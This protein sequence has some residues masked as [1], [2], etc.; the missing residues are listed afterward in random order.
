MA[1][2]IEAGLT[3]A[4]SHCSTMESSREV[5]FLCAVGKTGRSGVTVDEIAMSETEFLQDGVENRKRDSIA[6][7][8]C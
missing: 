1:R 6:S 5:K 3:G 7:R 4:L 2:R 8:C